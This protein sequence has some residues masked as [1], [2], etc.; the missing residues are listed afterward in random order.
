M[1]YIHVHSIIDPL[2]S[3]TCSIVEA[4]LLGQ[5]L[6]A[7]RALEG[8]SPLPLLVLPVVM[9]PGVVLVLVGWRKMIEQHFLQKEEL[10][11]LA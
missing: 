2:S 7:V 8:A 5:P 6:E 11:G 9:M 4:D 3:V 1:K 10:L